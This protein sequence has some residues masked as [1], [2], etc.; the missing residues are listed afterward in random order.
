M[1]IL[2]LN[3]WTDLS[4]SAA[5]SFEKGFQLKD[6]LNGLEGSWNAMILHCLRQSQRILLRCLRA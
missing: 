6:A 3:N 4:D 2:A 5:A 1:L